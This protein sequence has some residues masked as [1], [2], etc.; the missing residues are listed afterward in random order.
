MGE[1]LFLLVFIIM[2]YAIKRKKMKIVSLNFVLRSF[3]PIQIT[4]MPKYACFIQTS[5]KIMQPKS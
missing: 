4:G 1:P 2:I 5:T 3:Y